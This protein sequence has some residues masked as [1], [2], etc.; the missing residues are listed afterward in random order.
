MPIHSLVLTLVLLPLAAQEA[1]V[2][3]A[4]RV[5][6]GEAMHSNWSVR[7]RGNRIEAAGPQV[8]TGGAKLI[9]LG[10]R[11]L[12]PGMVEG[13]SHVL[14]HPYNEVPWNDQVA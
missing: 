5:F 11:T 10:N 2:L 4:A 7:V 8:D 3:K 13:H 1:I 12:M 9:D 14:L 6:D